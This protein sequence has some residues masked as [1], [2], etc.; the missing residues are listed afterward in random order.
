MAV[1]DE[2]PGIKVT[3]QVN[4]EDATEYIDPHASE[5]D[6]DGDPGCPVVSRYIESIDDVEFSITVAIDDD[7]YG[8]NDVEHDHLAAVVD[9]DKQQ[10]LRRVIRPGYKARVVT[11]VKSYSKGSNQWYRKPLKFSAI[12]IVEDQSPKKSNQDMEM[13]KN[14]GLIQIAFERKMRGNKTIPLSRSFKGTG[15][16]EVAEKTL[17]KRFISHSTSLGE[18]EV[19]KEPIWFSCPRIPTDHG[20]IAVFRFMYKSR[21]CLEEELIIPRSLDSNAK[22]ETGPTRSATY[23]SIRDL[24]MAEVL[25]LAQERLDQMNGIEANKYKCRSMKRE[26]DE[27]IDIDQEASKGRAAKRSTVTVD[28]TED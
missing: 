5:S 12:S 27:V 15:T 11:G 8:W 1:I 23:L 24:S 25:R 2:V 22:L 6:I 13:V 28:L 4:G 18:T 21:E 10:I 19:I 7:T 3:V 14:A 17:K 16:L 20:P 26:A 9:V